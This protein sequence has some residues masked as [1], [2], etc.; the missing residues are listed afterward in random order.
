MITSSYKWYRN[1]QCTET[2]RSQLELV[3]KHLVK[4]CGWHRE[5]RQAVC[6]CDQKGWT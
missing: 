3:I 2:V 4:G 5:H 6:T 1:P